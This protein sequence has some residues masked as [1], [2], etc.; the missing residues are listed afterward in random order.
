MI[1]N[2]NAKGSTD[3]VKCNFHGNLTRR[4]SKE[5]LASSMIHTH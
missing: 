2:A 3:F 1:G 4:F 5:Y